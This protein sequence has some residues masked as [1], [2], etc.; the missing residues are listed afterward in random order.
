MT[1]LQCLCGCNI[2]VAS[3]KGKDESYC[4]C[5]RCKQVLRIVYDRM[6]TPYLDKG[7]NIG[8]VR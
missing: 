6:G 4:T 2:K 5:V 7:I 8:A 3:A 1:A